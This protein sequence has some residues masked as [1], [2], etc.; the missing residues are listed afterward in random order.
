MSEI[1]EFQM[2]ADG[3]GT[4]DYVVAEQFEDGSIYTVADLDGDGLADVATVDYDGDGVAEETYEVP[5]GYTSLA[6]EE[7]T[8][9]YS[10]TVTYTSY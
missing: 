10:E 6:A 3:N 8:V 7:V 9:T 4:D 1:Y 5:G 2:D